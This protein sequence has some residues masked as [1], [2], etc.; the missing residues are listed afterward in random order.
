MDPSWNIHVTIAECGGMNTDWIGRS[1]IHTKPH[2]AYTTSSNPAYAFRKYCESHD[3]SS[4]TGDVDGIARALVNIGIWE[5]PPL[6]LALG[7]DALMM[8]SRKLHHMQEQLDR[9]KEISA[10]VTEDEKWAAFQAMI[11]LAANV[12]THAN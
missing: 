7:R 3:A 2:P 4:A 5:K 1:M 10:S 11:T 9:Y 6:R 8:I 12:V